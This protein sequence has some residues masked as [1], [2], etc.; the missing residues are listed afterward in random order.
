MIGLEVKQRRYVMITIKPG[1]IQT[2]NV[3]F[4]STTDAF[5]YRDRQKFE[6]P[7]L[8]RMIMPQSDYEKHNIT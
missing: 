7:S 4:S 5:L 1:L 8:R 6:W 2:D 3:R